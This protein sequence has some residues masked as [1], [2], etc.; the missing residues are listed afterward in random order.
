MKRKI[1]WILTGLLTIL[2]VCIVFLFPLK[3]ESRY[4]DT[5]TKE[6]ASSTKIANKTKK[7][8]AE[9]HSNK[10][11]EGS[12][13]T[14][15]RTPETIDKAESEPSDV[16]EKIQNNLNVYKK[17]IHQSHKKRLID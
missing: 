12:K 2:L 17:K 9:G 10:G 16:G 7:N 4:K 13:P 15:S 6:V 14:P 1:V 3:G 11:L 8:P 5:V